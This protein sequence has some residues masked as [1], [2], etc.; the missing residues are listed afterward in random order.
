M[1][2]KRTF[3][4]FFFSIL[5]FYSFSQQPEN[6]AGGFSVSPA[7]ELLR[8]THT[9]YFYAPSLKFN[10]RFANGLEPGLGLEYAT[11]PVHH[12]N[13]FILHRLR[14]I[15]VYGNLK[16]N[17]N[18]SKKIKPYAETSVG[19]SFNHYNIAE[20]ATPH[21]KRKVREPGFYT[22][23]GLGARYSL[24]EHLDTFLAVGLKGYKMSTNDLDINPHGLSFTLGFSIL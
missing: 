7:F 2:T 20:D 4:Y 14:F 6:I 10:Y 8:S 15:P 23:A 21:L 1:I 24:A 22:Y 16:Y 18:T 12:D 17:F 9:N 19:V 3:L 13:G 11:T 5:P